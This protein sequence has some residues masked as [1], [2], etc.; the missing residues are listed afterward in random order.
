MSLT[1]PQ[2]LMLGHASKVNFMRVQERAENDRVT[3]DEAR[4]AREELDRTDP[5]TFLGR[6]MSELTTD[7]MLQVLAVQPK[8]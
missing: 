8:G 1:L 3:A 4:K 6:R 7:E 2:I 5:M